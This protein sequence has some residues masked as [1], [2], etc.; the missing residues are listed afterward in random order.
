MTILHDACYNGDINKI[1]ELLQ[2]SQYKE[3]LNT[4]D[5][6]GNTVLELLVA[7]KMYDVLRSLSDTLVSLSFMFSIIVT[8]NQSNCVKYDSSLH[9]IMIDMNDHGAKEDE[10]YADLVVAIDKGVDI[11][12]RNNTLST[13]LH[14]ACEYQYPTIVKL[15]IE[16]GAD[17]NIVD[18]YLKQPLHYLCIIDNG[19]D[20]SIFES[21][22]RMLLDAGVDLT[23][24]DINNKTPLDILY[25]GFGYCESERDCRTIF[26][27]VMVEYYTNKN[28]EYEELKKEKELT[29]RVQ[30]LLVHTALA[31]KKLEKLRS[32]L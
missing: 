19:T 8:N 12:G 28:S 18:M 13:P 15:L 29:P 30:E 21:M 4:R 16:K 11:N 31:V 20:Y 25:E 14:I 9:N 6:R 5:E 1:M 26:A 3:Q 7:N 27:K 32:N 23:F 2:T 22:L 17:V 10:I 24:K